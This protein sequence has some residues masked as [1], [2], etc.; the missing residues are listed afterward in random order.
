VSAARLPRQALAPPVRDLAT[1]LAEDGM[2]DG[3]GAVVRQLGDLAEEAGQDAAGGPRGP[4]PVVAVTGAASGLGL[5]LT[6]RLAV[7]AEVGRVIAID[8]HRGDVSGV[9]WRITDVRDP[10]L[11][12]RLADVDVIVHADLDLS[13]DAESRARRA[14]N[15]RGAQTVLTAAAAGGVGRVVLVTSAMVYGA[16]HDNPVPLPEDA[17]LTAD[18]D[19]SV[20]GDLLE[21]EHLA[22][23]SSRAHL[24][25]EV[26][27]VRPAALVGD[28][29]DTVV[30]RHFE[31]PRLLAVKGCA[32]RWQFC[33]LD[34]LA[35]ALELALTGQVPGS[36]AVGSDGWLEQ[37]QLEE[38][39]GLRRF[40]LPAGLT[41]ATA[42]RLHRAGLTPVPVADLHYVVYPWVVDCTALRQ[43]GWRPRYD[44]AEALQVLLDQRAGHHAV[45]GRRLAKK[46]ATIT[47]AGATVAVIGTAAIV[48]QVR[49]RRRGS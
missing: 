18:S 21:I 8:E 3:P 12:G 28:G 5:A 23:R 37:E 6:C 15:V 11:A 40:E 13:P 41:F 17:P 33:H 7:S 9:T 34:D 4:G 1:G 16:H 22:E 36:F 43:A 47:A 30:T 39:S 42:Q 29:I 35:S 25:L 24:G 38:L 48:R 32:A 2:A 45:A 19:G 31:A 49:R 14:F 46:D 10:A 26:V 27:V 20:V 44:N